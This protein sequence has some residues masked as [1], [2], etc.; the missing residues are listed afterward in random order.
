MTASRH[1]F[2]FP[3]RICVRAL[4]VRLSLPHK[5]GHREGRELA[6]P[7]ARLQKKSRRQ[8]PQVRPRHPGLPCAIVL[9]AASRSPRCAG[10][11]GHRARQRACARCAGYLR[12]SIRT[13]RLDRPHQARSSFRTIR[14]YRSPPLRFVTIG[15]NALFVAS[16]M[17]EMIVVI[18]PTRQ[19][20]SYAANWHDGQIVHAP[21]H[22][23]RR[24]GPLTQPAPGSPRSD[25]SDHGER[26]TDNVPAGSVASAH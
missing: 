24:L 21:M 26:G 6:A 10:L 22:R 13:A 11:S 3:R 23:R 9:T 17:T 14:V 15:R 4:Q 7:M 2:S 18:C 20:R 8:S 19:G 25:G 16:R 1:T 5:R 12:R